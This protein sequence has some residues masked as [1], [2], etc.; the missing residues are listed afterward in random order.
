MWRL[1]KGWRR[2]ALPRSLVVGLTIVLC[3]S[4]P[5]LGLVF[6]ASTLHQRVPRLELRTSLQSAPYQSDAAWYGA[7]LNRS[8]AKP[9]NWIRNAEFAPYTVRFT[10]P[11]VYKSDN[12][13]IELTMRTDPN[14]IPLSGRLLGARV[15][16]EGRGLTEEQ[17]PETYVEALEPFTFRQP[18]R[19]S[20]LLQTLPQDS[21][22]LDLAM[23]TGDQNGTQDTVAVGRKGLIVY[24]PQS[25]QPRVVSSFTR[26]DLVQVE[27]NSMGYVALSSAGN[28]W[29]SSDGQHWQIFSEAG[30][31]GF[32][33]RL[34]ASHEGFLLFYS[35]RRVG[36]TQA[37]WRLHSLT[38]PTDIQP[39]GCCS[40]EGS[41]V[42]PTALGE[43]LVLPVD[44]SKPRRWSALHNLPRNILVSAS[45]GHLL[46]FL[47]KAGD[48]WVYRPREGLLHLTRLVRNYG[49]LEAGEDRCQRLL[50]FR[51]DQVGLCL[52]A[53]G[54]TVFNPDTRHWTD[55]R[56]AGRP[57]FDRALLLPQAGL[58]TLGLDGQVVS[59][60]LTVALTLADQSLAAEL[61]TGD[62]L[63]IEKTLEPLNPPPYWQ[64]SSGWTTRI[65]QDPAGG[66][67]LCLEPG[68]G[69]DVPVS[70]P[71]ILRQ[72][73]RP[74]T[75]TWP[76]RSPLRLHFRARLLPASAAKE[77]L[78]KEGEGLPGRYHQSTPPVL[79][80]PELLTDTPPGVEPDRSL[81]I[82]LTGLQQ[83]Y[84]HTLGLSHEWKDYNL[85]FVSSPWAKS[86]AGK[87]EDELVLSFRAPAGKIL[88]ISS[89]YLGLDSA[90]P[91][92]PY[93]RRLEEL[94]AT[95]P[96]V[97]RLGTVSI[98]RRGSSSMEWLYRGSSG[99]TRVNEELREASGF[100]LYTELDWAARAK[101]SPWLVINPFASKEELDTLLEYLAG[102]VQ[103]AAGA[104]R[105][106]QGRRAPWTLE[107]PRI[108]L[109]FCD[110]DDTLQTDKEKG[111]VV[112]AMVRLVKSS[113]YYPEMKNK[114]VLVDG[115]RYSK[116]EK[117]SV[118]DEHATQ[119]SPAFGEGLYGEALMQ[120]FQNLFP[121]QNLQPDLGV[122]RE[123]VAST[124]LMDTEQRPHSLARLMDLALVGQGR[125]AQMLLYD[126]KGY[127]TKSSPELLPVLFRLLAPRTGGTHTLALQRGLE[128]GVG[129]SSDSLQRVGTYGFLSPEGT[130][131]LLVT[132]TNPQDAGLRLLLGGGQRSWT[133][134]IY[135]EKG[136]QKRSDRGLSSRCEFSVPP[137]GVA[138]IEI[139]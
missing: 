59:Y 50:V 19:L 127:D 113:H 74:D 92:G 8:A 116:N 52:P 95:K 132:N 41:Y 83:P 20:D 109:E 124:P 103:T 38:L 45:Y 93:P 81:Q 16:P 35:T 114:L 24:N 37:D 56:A 119:L 28:V 88:E 7:G 31:Q 27:G 43:S 14:D 18:H 25:S 11:I 26:E 134:H 123:L 15:R 111:D 49:E 136:K 36:V 34:L 57:G 80:E 9:A 47:D 61:H 62:R 29:G 68:S 67:S 13:K 121:R 101:A 33:R 133:V 69:P 6:Y 55:L 75:D 131:Q 1:I 78:E 115:M 71:L 104:V 128:P 94:T 73:L 129:W 10:A 40:Y 72:I 108:F 30:K 64:W 3:L 4:L 51:E 87:P 58:L 46:Y 126:A 2:R 53:S 66:N 99:L 54:L 122:S 5:V 44:G 84:A 32:C 48:L 12:G 106:S 70:E 85:R 65:L 105:R 77:L 120:A 17:T 97:L 91:L 98:G 63:T 125:L 135:D 90:D 42:L 22:F 86:K 110:E 60:Q 117:L 21:R 112:D 138:E 102:S 82:S 107:F 76:S 100:P 39:E 79:P 89:L 130:A 137:G 139:K 23:R 96:A 118:A